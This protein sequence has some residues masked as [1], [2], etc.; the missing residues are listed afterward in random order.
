MNNFLHV[1]AL[2]LAGRAKEALQAAEA[3]GTEH[4]AARLLHL[5][6]L[7]ELSLTT[8]AETLGNTLLKQFEEGPF[9]LEASLWHHFNHLYDPEHG[10]QAYEAIRTLTAS[11]ARDQQAPLYLKARAMDV[12]SRARGILLLLGLAPATERVVIVDDLKKSAIGFRHAGDTIEYVLALRRAANFC[13]SEPFALQEQG[14][15]LLRRTADAA[16]RTRQPLLQADALL[17]SLLLDV[18]ARLSAQ[19]PLG[20]AH[21][22]SL[23]R[24]LRRVEQLFLTGGHAWG[25]AKTADEVG[26]LFLRYGVEEG[27]GMVE[28]AREQYLTHGEIL[29]AQQA[30][31]NLQ[32]YYT[33][34]GQWTLA[35]EA[36]QQATALKSEIEFSLS[37]GVQDLSIADAMFRRGEVGAGIEWLRKRWEVRVNKGNLG[38]AYATMLSSF[39]GTIGRHDE[40]LQIIDDTVA[41]L[42]MQVGDSA[43]LS[44]LLYVASSI[45]GYER[46]LEYLE[47]AIAIDRVIRDT[48]S[49]AKHLEARAF[50]RV[51]HRQSMNLRP[52]ML[53]EIE[54]DYL[55]AEAMIANRA[56][57]EAQ[58]VM[59]NILQHWGLDYFIDRNWERCGEYLTKAENWCRQFKLKSHLAYTLSQ[60]GL[61]LI[62]L[63]RQFNIDYYERAREKLEEAQTL[64]REIPVVG[65]HWRVA[66]HIGLCPWETG[67][68]MESGSTA[69]MALYRQAESEFRSAARLLDNLRGYATMGSLAERQRSGIGFGVRKQTLYNAGMQVALLGLGD[70]NLAFEWLER[71][72]SRAFLDTLADLTPPNDALVDDPMIME[73]LV[74]RE[75]L[76]AAADPREAVAIQHSLDAHL[77][78]MTSN[79][80]LR[81][82][83]KVRLGEVVDWPLLRTQMIEQEQTLN[84]RRV[85]LLGYWYQNDR[86]WAVGMRSDW[87]SP[88]FQRLELDIK[89]LNDTICQYFRGKNS[90]RLMLKDFGE[91]GWLAMSGLLSPLAD[92]ASQGDIIGFIPFGLL[93]DVPL[94]TLHINGKV[95][96]LQHPCFYVPSASV[97]SVLWQRRPSING[98]KMILGNPTLD[99]PMAAE[100]AR[101]IARQIG[102]NV[103]LENAV[104]RTAV[105][106]ALATASWMHFA[107]HGFFNTADGFKSHLKLA[108]GMTI[109]ANEI[110]L[111]DA[112][113]T[114]TV[115]LSGCE[116]G[117]HQPQEGDESIG[118][119]RALLH[120]QVRQVV[121]SQW[122]VND[123]DALLLLSGFY[124]YIEEN[125]GHSLAVALQAS[126]RS[127]MDKFP[128]A[129]F[130]HWAG[131]V[132][133]GDFN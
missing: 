105:E 35:D 24:R 48:L 88:R 122:R 110:L 95:C 132:L 43:I 82:H 19:Q 50:L 71:L 37:E 115:V 49:L 57:L 65:E 45:A 104:D 38:A 27:V 30:W 6:L 9:R 4:P 120:R 109:S 51:R 36:E 127:Y 92:W 99:L 52:V 23:Q 83:A 13:L 41:S 111:L 58:E 89:A 29:H 62:E 80:A 128:N 77:E 20:R 75:Q 32:V 116:T 53:P 54:A 17:R 11:V 72:K 1:F 46:G 61:V 100:E 94:H 33:H 16:S 114:Q 98:K 124:Q 60:Q 70:D 96:I 5:R 10:Q 7:C 90:V 56:D 91:A 85:I 103:L 34:R 40:A 31:R 131:F 125:P 117:L 14:K 97:L 126:I 66:F 63:G 15:A 42:R 129:S 25:N 101:I 78:K 84:G 3:A 18:E 107:G 81:T 130:Y 2:Y 74:L 67:Q 64:F 106:K 86:I 121:G 102:A 28:Y 112:V 68:R 93:H 47:Q 113:C 8:Q 55:E 69:Q 119:I 118:L 87:E 76:F 79:P 39:L 21:W 73:E 26:I 123:D 133:H 22:N 12:W 108:D 59:A 44:H